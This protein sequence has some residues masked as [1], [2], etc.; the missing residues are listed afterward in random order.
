MSYQQG[1]PQQQP[2]GTPPGGYPL[3]PARGGSP[4]TAIIAAVLG[5]IAAAA[6]V[7]VTIKRLSDASE[8]PFDKL[9]GPYKTVVFVWFAAALILLVG[10]I[11]VFFRKLAGAFITVL[12][13][14]AGIAAVLLYPVILGDSLGIKI[15][16]GDYL[17]AV[18]KFDGTEST[19]SAI[20]LI[21]SPL[22]LILA[23][24]PPTLNYLRG[25]RAGEQIP[26]Q[27][28]W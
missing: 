25:S 19:F 7:V 4:A 5:L 18:F 1:Y 10:V 16:M 9:P 11:I 6:L 2:V 26:Q 27:P 24:L 14:L 23:I 22:A 21:A 20:A 17:D 3:P 8:I 13:G 12:G 28:N 15:P